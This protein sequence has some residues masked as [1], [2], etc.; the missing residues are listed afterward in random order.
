MFW[1]HDCRLILGWRWL[2]K[3]GVCVCVYKKFPSDI[4]LKFSFFLPIFFLCFCIIIRGGSLPFWLGYIVGFGQTHNI[5]VHTAPVSAQGVVYSFPEYLVGKLWST[6]H[7]TN[8]L[9]VPPGYSTGR[10]VLHQFPPTFWN[11]L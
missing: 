8:I 11:N 4:H 10:S 6:Q 7:P 5:L 9:Y 3:S 1:R 2:V